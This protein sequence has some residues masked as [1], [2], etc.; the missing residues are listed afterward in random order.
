MSVVDSIVAFLFVQVLATF[1]LAYR[2][3]RIVR[4]LR[5]LEEDVDANTAS[6]TI[7]SKGLS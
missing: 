6:I 7:L 2:Q 5:L 4:R 3:C 1:A